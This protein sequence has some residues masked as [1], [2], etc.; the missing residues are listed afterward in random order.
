MREHILEGFYIGSEQGG[1]GE[2]SVAE[3]KHSLQAWSAATVK[4]EYVL[5]IREGD[6]PEV[7]AIVVR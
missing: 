1:T 6:Y 5:E 7:E 3:W 2:A 4:A